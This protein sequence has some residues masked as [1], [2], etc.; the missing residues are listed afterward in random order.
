MHTRGRV[1]RMTV[2]V[3][4]LKGPDA[5]LYYVEA[6]PS[7]YLDAGEP[8]GA[9]QGF[10]A[11]RLGL[12]NEVDDDAF[13]ALMAGLEP[14][15]GEALGRNYG[16]GSVRGFDVTASAPKS[17]S[18]LFALGDDATR[19]AVLDAHDSAV[20]AMV[21]WIEDHAHTRYRI[22]G[23][24]R[25][26][27]AEGI[28]AACFRQHTSRALDPQLHT[29]VVIANRVVADDGRW[30]ALDARTI[31]CDQRTLSALYHASLRTE[32]TRSLGVE[33]AEPVHGIAEMKGVPD[34]VLAEFSSRT[35]AVEER[36]EDKLER[37]VES[38]ERDPTPRERWRLEREAVTESRPSKSHGDDAW[39]LHAEWAERA[40]AIGH[41]PE[42]VV[43]A[44]VSQPSAGRA[45][46]TATQELIVSRALKALTETQSSWRPAELVRELAAA[47]PTDVALDAEILVPW[48]HQLGE[49]VIAERLVD[50]SRPIP[51]GVALRRDGR[52]IT[53]SVADRAL[54][55]PEILAQEERLI[56]WAE[57]RL[58]AVGGDVALDASGVSLALSKP[59][60]EVAG[61]VA[62]NR[63]LALV[64]GPAGT[65]KTSAVA[66]AVEQLRAD[67][68]AVFG[69]APSAGAA[70][71]LGTDAG[72]ASD[73]LD[74][75]LV[76]HR[77]DRPP[78]HRYD[79]PPGATVVVDEAAMVSTPKL[80]ELAELADARGWRMAL[81]GDPL[82]FSAV[83]RS[84]MFGHLINCYGAIELDRV[85]RFANEWE[86]DASLALRRGDT[87][88]LHL[89]DHHGRLHGGTPRQMEEAVVDAWW[90]ARGR[91]E[92]V[93]MMAPTNET[94]VELN[95]RA[96]DL[97]AEAGEIDIFGPSVSVGEYQF[98]RGDVVAT[99]RNDREL[100]TD[101]GL[102][103]KNRDLWK[104]ADVH[105]GD[106]TV[107]GRTGTVRLPAEYVAEHL[108]LAYAQT[109]HAN[110]GRTVDRSL[111]FLDGPT[112]TRGVYVPMTRGR[113]S[114]E[115]FVALQGEQTAVDLVG[116]ALV[117]D[118]I[119]EPAIARR[120]ELQRREPDGD[121]RGLGDQLEGAHLRKLLER[122]HEI[123]RSL[124]RAVDAIGRYSEQLDRSTQRND[125][126]AGRLAEAELTRD[127]SEDVLEAFD[128][129]LLWRLHRSEISL[130]QGNL[131][132]AVGRIEACTA[133][134]AELDAH[135]PELEAALERA[136]ATIRE[137]P[138]LD[139]E[140]HGI[141]RE[142]DRDLAARIPGLI[143]DPPDHL[144]DRLGPRP[145]QGAAADLWDEA[146][147]R[148]DQHCAAFDVTTLGRSRGWDDTAFD[149]S[150]R[151]AS[152]ACESLDR[153]VERVYTIEPP[154]LALG[155]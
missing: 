116:K 1:A 83:G 14:R 16:E 9:W 11:S 34:D 75:L 87:E 18:V 144:V 6:L 96:Q 128:R 57:R 55:T 54:T 92:S 60:L 77:L 141:R 15:T 143:A 91:S 28:A 149:A 61:A 38:F 26:L 25:T 127:K 78:D 67:G 132:Q 13:L 45:M 44:A 100:H 86:R 31:K 118:W 88:I 63:E 84:G 85:H 70:E 65:G 40:T 110:Q 76:E 33:W 90:Q 53:E 123:T 155:L 120:A 106:V 101:R 97:R 117:R 93:A 68:R 56:A 2:R 32:L 52:P 153:T 71:V 134:M 99:R 150:Q 130:A 42:Y 27:D 142:L 19:A 107:S 133:E 35:K 47:V 98:F 112:D 24:V 135:R 146:A 139:R 73:T 122:E 22:G 20:V 36:I 154:H 103:V 109:S 137:R 30:L 108:E 17:V 131:N 59:Q 148:I 129:P 138:S 151:A 140:R 152:E 81:V 12:V 105:R 5:G 58:A 147:A 104:V 41:D 37:F 102:M 64:V 49:A 95:L 119:D 29:H 7:Y 94:V 121:G 21:D 51:D 74:K 43:G 4:T 125:E 46:D 48:L 126:L 3:T 124:S 114:N 39:S 66:P 82:Q 136:Q 62:G 79:L 50:I 69:V 80:A 113:Q 89:Y 8:A 145:A 72:L 23:Q 10:G 115:V 111:L